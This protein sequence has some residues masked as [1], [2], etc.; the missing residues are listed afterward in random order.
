MSSSHLCLFRL[1]IVFFLRFSTLFSIV[2]ELC[3]SH[4]WHFHL[5]SRTRHYPLYP[6]VTVH[7]IPCVV[8]LSDHSSFL[9]S[10]LP[11]ILIPPFAPPF[12]PLSS[13][14]SS[15]FT[16]LSSLHSSFLPSLLPSTLTLYSFLSSSPF[17]PPL[18]PL[19]SYSFAF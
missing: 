12:N 11:S 16:P 13:L 8:E 14:S 10:L 1:L 3:S 15:H 4:T 6:L 9:P 2:F 19:S 17:I 5:P 18:T 7:H